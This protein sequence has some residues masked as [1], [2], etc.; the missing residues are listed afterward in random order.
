M[1]RKLILFSSVFLPIT[2]CA[3]TTSVD[4]FQVED[5]QELVSSARIELCGFETMMDRRGH[6]FWA[7]QK[8][9]CEG[10]GLIRL[11][12]NDGSTRECIVGYV[13]GLAQNH[14]YSALPNHC[15]AI[16]S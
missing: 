7:T 12:Y 14:N 8:I 9:T 2:A 5:E 16:V 11:T 15:E 6:Y 4:T 1:A 13:T 3:C 10:A